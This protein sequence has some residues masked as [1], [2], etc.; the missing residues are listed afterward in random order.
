MLY[1]TLWT[2][3][4]AELATSSWS[5]FRLATLAVSPVDSREGIAALHAVIERVWLCDEHLTTEL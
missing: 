1:P 2:R 5:L 4:C 3:L